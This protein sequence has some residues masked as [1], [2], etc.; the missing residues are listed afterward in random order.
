VL[1]FNLAWTLYVR[2]RGIINLGRDGMFG[3]YIQ[4]IFR[5]ARGSREA[6]AWLISPGYRPE[7][8]ANLTAGWYR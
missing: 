8:P 2:Q 6:A 3:T 5:D 1:R 7:T 4:G